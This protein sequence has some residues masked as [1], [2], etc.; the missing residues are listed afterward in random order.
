VSRRRGGH[1]PGGWRGTEVWLE[2]DDVQWFGELGKTVRAAM[3]LQPLPLVAGAGAVAQPLP[4]L[5]A[6]SRG[7]RPASSRRRRLATRLAPTVT[8][9]AAAGVGVPLLIASQPAELP[10]PLPALSPSSTVTAQPAPAET[11]PSIPVVPVTETASPPA[12][13]PVEAAATTPS[14][15]PFPAIRWRE[16]HA[17]G[18]PHIGTLVDGVRL[19]Q[20]S[21]DWVTWDPVRDQVPN[22]A[23]RLYGTDELVRLAVDVIAAYRLAHPDAPRVVIGDLSL[24]GGGE[25]DE[26][27]SHENGL[28]LDVYYPRKDGRELAPMTV[29]QV[30]VRLAQDLLDRFVAAGASVVFVGYSVP[31]RGPSGVVVP[32]ANHDN[33]MHVRIGAGGAVSGD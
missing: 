3:P 13:A 5:R 10:L 20:K 2:P 9:L 30:D 11:R 25:I 12:A 14:K 8:G 27:A 15:P 24:R 29:N 33:H 22:R 32:Y 4:G 19:P 21:P 23:E 17:L 26:H 1:V 6:P 31:L 28:D 7:V 16:S 18:V